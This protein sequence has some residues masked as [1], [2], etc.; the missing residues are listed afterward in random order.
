MEKDLFE[1][2]KEYFEKQGFTCDGEVLDIDLYMEKGDEKVAVEL[3][4]ELNFRVF[5][6]AAIRQKQVETVYIGTFN[7]K[8]M[9]SHAFKDKLYLLKLL[10][11]GLIVVSKKTGEVQVVSEPVVSELSAF[12][13][14][15]AK[16]SEALS[17]EFNKRKAK[18]NTGG[19]HGKKLITSYREEALLVLDSLAELG[20]EE[21]NTVVRKNSGIKKTSEILRNNYYGWFEK[22]ETGLY[23]ITD[24]GYNALEEF[25]DTIFKLRTMNVGE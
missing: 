6:Q 9:R 17:K 24:E 3:K 20:G 23:R 19:V 4:Q 11:I 18:N 10:G 5:Q 16:K 12:Q 21:K 7:P 15:N 2:I 8:N 1:P 22:V 14:R 25:E 13:K